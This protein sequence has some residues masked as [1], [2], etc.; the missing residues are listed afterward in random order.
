MSDQPITHELMFTHLAPLSSVECIRYFREPDLISKW[1]CDYSRLNPDG[2][3][4]LHWLQN[5]I[6][7][8]NFQ[9]TDSPDQLRIQQ[10]YWYQP[11][12][13]TTLSIQFIEQG[14]QTRIS[15][16]LQGEISEEIVEEYRYDWKNLKLLGM[17][18][19]E[20]IQDGWA[21]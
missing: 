9:P 12:L 14:G 1:F 16:S 5:Q 3:L 19:Q 8:W 13:E 7:H 15:V 6:V 21:W 17:P 4:E 20:S 18:P 11:E 10:T 2:T